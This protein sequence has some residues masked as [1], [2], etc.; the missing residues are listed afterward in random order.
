[1]LEGLTIGGAH[2]EAWGAEGRYA[3]KANG[4][5]ALHSWELLRHPA[6]AKSSTLFSRTVAGAGGQGQASSSQGPPF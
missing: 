6:L 2:R 4:P 3:T 1:M 5:T